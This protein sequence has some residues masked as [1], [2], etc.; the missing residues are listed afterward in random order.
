MMMWMLLFW[1][2]K[3]SVS[4]MIWRMWIVVERIGQRILEEE[5]S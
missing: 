4:S 5:E 2:K 3:P 1:K